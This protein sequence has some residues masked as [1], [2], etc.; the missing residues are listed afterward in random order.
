MRP[1]MR[2]TMRPTTTRVSL[3]PCASKVGQISTA[4][5]DDRTVDGSRSFAWRTA[6]GYE[7]S[8][9]VTERMRLTQ[10]GFDP[11]ELDTLR[12]PDCVPRPKK[13][14]DDK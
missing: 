13:P 14:P 8:F 7:I 11:A 6:D 5:A 1:T 10:A 3:R 2:L 4:R 9:D 12:F